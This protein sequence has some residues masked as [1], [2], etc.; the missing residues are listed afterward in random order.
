MTDPSTTHAPPDWRANN[1]C[2]TETE[3]DELLDYLDLRLG[4]SVSEVVR[5][6]YLRL[7]TARRQPTQEGSMT[8]IPK[9]HDDGVFHPPQS[10]RPIPDR[11]P[12]RGMV[13]RKVDVTGISGLGHI[14]EYCVFSDGATAWRW[15]GG[16]PQNQPKWEFY[17]N[18]GVAPFLQI[19]GH[20]GNTE[21][22]WID[23][24]PPEQ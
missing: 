6:L 20:N 11:Q 3:A 24:P 9:Q 22:V 16:P 12:S 19:S 17:D 1:L 5:N 15:L 23:E 18:P 14:V 21:L 10:V 7:R 13:V 8:Y 4:H 2:I